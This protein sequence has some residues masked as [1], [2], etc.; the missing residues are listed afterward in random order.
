M[1]ERLEKS[2]ERLIY[3]GR[4]YRS[5]REKFIETSDPRYSEKMDRCLRYIITGTESLKIRYEEET[6]KDVRTIGNMPDFKKESEER[7]GIFLP[8]SLM[9]E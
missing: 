8:D 4:V 9:K 3:W 2:I 5:S 7:E 6:G 1:N